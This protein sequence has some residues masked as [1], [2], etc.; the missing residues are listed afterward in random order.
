MPAALPCRSATSAVPCCCTHC[1]GRVCLGL[2]WHTSKLKV[3]YPCHFTGFWQIPNGICHTTHLPVLRTQQ[4]LPTKMICP[5]GLS[6]ANQ[7]TLYCVLLC[8]CVCIPHACL[9][10]VQQSAPHCLRSSG[11]MLPSLLCQELRSH[12]PCFI[13][14][15]PAPTL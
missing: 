4:L 11:P 12:A 13:L 7:E 9:L 15:P 1:L 6:R 10:S 8:V 5:P 2:G 3:G 14:C